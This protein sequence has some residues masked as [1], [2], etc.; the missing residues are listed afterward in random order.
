MAEAHRISL[1]KDFYD[2]Y[3]SIN[4]GTGKGHSVLELITIFEKISGEKLNYEIVDRRPGDVSEIWS[5][6]S[7]SE[8][9]IDWKANRTIEES[10]YSHLMYSKNLKNC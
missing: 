5:D 8:E 3:T 1:V 2:N 9:I 6:I 7:Y 4:I 10:V